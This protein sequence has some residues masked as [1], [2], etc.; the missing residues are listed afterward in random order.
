MGQE[1]LLEHR[2]DPKVWICPEVTAWEERQKPPSKAVE[3]Q[4]KC[5]K[6]AGKRQE[7][8]RGN[9]L[10]ARNAE[11]W[12]SSLIETNGK[13]GTRGLWLLLP[14]NKQSRSPMAKAE[15]PGSFPTARD[16]P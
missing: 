3:R 16:A 8:S 15:I 5:R 14:T 12:K 13:R 10:A 7:S 1:L 6:K 11:V 4:E 2:D 9:S